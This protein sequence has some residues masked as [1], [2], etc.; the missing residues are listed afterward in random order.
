MVYTAFL[1]PPLGPTA[2]LLV[3]CASLAEKPES[4]LVHRK[5]CASCAAHAERHG[6]STTS[7]RRKPHVVQ[8]LRRSSYGHYLVGCSSACV[9][10]KGKCR[11]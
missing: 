7:F 5:R 1:L 11:E 3:K 4:L 6:P 9:R 8:L 2:R 10:G